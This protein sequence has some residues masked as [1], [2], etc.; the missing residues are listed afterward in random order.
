MRTYEATTASLKEKVGEM[1]AG[2]RVY[3]SGIIYTA[4][5]AAHKRLHGDLDNGCEPFPISGSI[6]YYSGPCPGVIGQPILAAG[7]TTSGRMDS[8]TSRLLSLGLLATIGKGPRSSDVQQT[9]QDCGAVYLVATGGAGALLAQC[10]TG[11]S[12]V[13]YPELGP[14]AILAL[15]V[16]RFPLIVADDVHGNSIYRRGITA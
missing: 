15:K 10:I 9:A 11:Y 13:A 5:D 2:D 7:P 14:E 4:R 16:D 8:Y 6:I 3:L 1:R 12:V